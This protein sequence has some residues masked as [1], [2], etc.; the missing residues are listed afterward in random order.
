MTALAM[1]QNDL[2]ALI[3]G[4]ALC[5]IAAGLFAFGLLGR[6]IANIDLPLA[7]AFAALYGLRL[8]MRTES[9][10][11]MLGDPAWLHYVHADLE[12]LVPVPGALLFQRFF[13]ERLRRLNRVATIAFILGAA[14]GIP[15]DIAKGH[16]G[17]FLP[18]T[19]ALVL[20]FVATFLINIV[21]P[22]PDES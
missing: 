3:V 22:A 7:G 12:Y 1:L 9:I 4:V 17:A 10:T 6:R 21:M 8:I 11:A 15:Y 20:F 5:T 14:A 19:N 13:G 16:P 2:P 18:V